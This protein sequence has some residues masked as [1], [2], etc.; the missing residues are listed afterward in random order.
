MIAQGDFLRLLLAGTEERK[1]IFRDIFKTEPYDRFQQALKEAA[2]DLSRQYDAA[3]GNLKAAVRE[4]R[5]DEDDALTAEARKAK[6]NEFPI[7]EAAALLETLT[8]RDSERYDASGAAL[9]KL[10]Q[11]LETLNEALGR[12]KELDSQRESLRDAGEELLQ[13]TSALETLRAAWDKA[14]ERKPEM[15][16]LGAE[17]PALESRLP[18]YEKREALRAQKSATDAELQSA[19]AERVEL[20]ARLEEGEARLSERRAEREEL[21]EAPERHARLITDKEREE[22]ACAELETLQGN[23]ARY[24]D[25]IDRRGAQTERQS[26]LAGALRAARER[27]PEAERLDKAV[28][29]LEAELPRYESLNRQEAQCREMEGRIQSDEISLKADREALR[30]LQERVSGCRDELETLRNADAELE[31]AQRESERLES[32]KTELR[33]LRE[34]LTRYRDTMAEL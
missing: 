33:D 12:A 28:A 23:L 4:I 15:E 34:T 6:T 17:V 21:A 11:D 13:K 22:N 10:N 16:R 7:A 31:R 24:R 27:L 30:E 18:D 1:K 3:N 26:E 9:D 29:A 2:L 14:L 32:R 19:E 25:L 20:A 8:Q 5:F